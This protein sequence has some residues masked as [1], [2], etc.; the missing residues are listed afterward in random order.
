MDGSGCGRLAGG[1]AGD[2]AGVEAW[3]AALAAF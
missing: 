1:V 3:C 2:V